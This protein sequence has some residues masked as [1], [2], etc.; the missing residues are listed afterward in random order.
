MSNTTIQIRRSTSANTPASLAQGELAFTSNGDTLWVGSPSGSNTANVIHIGAKISYVGNATHLGSSTTGSNS[1]LASTY[2]IKN[3]VANQISSFTTTISGLTD[4]DVT[5]V[6]NNNLLVYSEA[7]GKWEDHTIAGTANQVNV[8]FSSQNITV[9]LP[10]DVTISANLTVNNSLYVTGNSEF[11]DWVNIQVGGEWT[12]HSVTNPTLQAEAN[13]D[14]WTQ[15]SIQNRNPGVNASA[16]FIAYPNNTLADDNTGFIDLGITSN[17]YNQAAYSVT[18]PNDGYLFASARAGDNLGGSLVLATDSTGTNN[19]IKFFVGGFT[20][21]HDQ[22]HMVLTGNNRNLGIGNGNPEHKLSVEGSAYFN[23][24]TTIVGTANVS[25]AIN[26]GSNVGI[27]TSSISVG[28]ST[29]NAYITANNLSINGS[30][31]STLKIGSGSSNTVI[32]DGNITSTGSANIGT[33]ISVGT[34]VYI[35][36]SS[37]TVG[38]SSVNAYIS[39][40]AVAF[41]SSLAAGNTT[42]T[43][44]LAA[45]NTTITGD[46]TVTGTVTTVDSTNLVVEDSLIKLARNQANTTTFVDAVDIGFYGTYGNTGQIVYTGLARDASAN[47]YVLFDGLI[48]ESPDNVVNTAAITVTTLQAYL[49]SGALVSNSSAVQITANSSVSVS[50]TANTLSLSTAL[51]VASG[52]TGRAT[53]SNNAVVVGNGTGQ[54]TLVSSSTEGHVLQINSSGAPTFGGLDGGTF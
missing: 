36:T 28:N 54:V 35:T 20:Y 1:E 33:A 39:A 9:G 42:I 46:L 50:I 17:G 19:D 21:N 8:S 40:T 12:P 22:P 31:G 45:G 52:G 51:G 34:N 27:T 6:A 2:A 14:N 18:K 38:N 44:T 30:T 32:T 3:Y 26:I 49:N 41:D 15:V 11:S 5:G 29:V 48:N 4:V 24:N 13:T 25:T 10:D 23:G 7:T 37:I 47:V 53:L 43:G 16:D